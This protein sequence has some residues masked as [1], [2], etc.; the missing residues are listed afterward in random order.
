M[1]RAIHIHLKRTLLVLSTS[2]LL[3][4]MPMQAARAE[5]IKELQAKSQTLQAQI[6]ANNN[7]LVELE[8]KEESLQGKIAELNTEISTAQTEIELTQVKIKELQQRLKETEAEL[9]RQKGLLKAALRALYSRRDA[10][11]V[12]LLVASDSFSDFIDS[13]EYL[14]RLQTAVKDS[15]D[16]VVKLKQQIE[17]EKFEQEALLQKQK[18]QKAV[19]AA[20]RQEQQDIL[21]Q[22]QGE[23]SKYRE[24]V[25]AQQA[26]LEK[27]EAQLAALLSAGNFVSLGPIGRGQVVGKV[28]STG[29][30]TGPHIHFQVYHNGVTT[31]PYV[32]GSLINGYSWPLLNGVGWISQSYG[33]VAEYWSYATKCNNNQNSFHNGLDI[34]ASAYT[35]IVAAA[36]GEIV[37][38]GCRAGLGYVVV[39][40]HGGGWQTWYPHQVTPEGQVY[41]YCG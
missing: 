18:E 32:G 34:A 3:L 22:T 5:T 17:K 11:T 24:I 19:L 41:G 33:C 28:G 39:I 20:K 21:D 4:A 12:E 6:D 36:D 25:A 7:Q 14:E 38:K 30:S 27:A 31:N 10:S 2:M 29:Y 23:E 15:A 26:E 16:K 8:K 37:F 1:F 13:Q 40:D 9:E 35:T